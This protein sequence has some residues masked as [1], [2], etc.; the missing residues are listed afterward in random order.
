MILDLYRK[1]QIFVLGKLQAQSISDQD[2]Q[3]IVDKMVQEDKDYA[4]QN[5]DFKIDYG[6]RTTYDADKDV[7][8]GP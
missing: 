8:S 7:S 2:I 5:V 1:W 6:N 3:N 4:I